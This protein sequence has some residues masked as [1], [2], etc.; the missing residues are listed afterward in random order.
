[1][2]FIS[3]L[4]EIT[5]CVV[6]VLIMLGWT[7]HCAVIVVLYPPDI[8]NYALCTFG[9]QSTSLLVEIAQSSQKSHRYVACQSSS[10]FWFSTYIFLVM[11]VVM[12][13]GIT[14][15]L[16]PLSSCYTT[17]CHCLCYPSPASLRTHSGTY[18]KWHGLQTLTLYSPEHELY[19]LWRHLLLKNPKNSSFSIGAVP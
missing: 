4:T 2:V 19:F 18:E 10:L 12:S 1:M 15:V 16:L 3:L 7:M 17:I 13:S 14:S 5:H 6:S 8:P 9:S 11:S